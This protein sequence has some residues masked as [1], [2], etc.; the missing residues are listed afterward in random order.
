VEQV[1]EVVEADGQV[2]MILAEELP[3]EVDDLP[4]QLLGGLEVSGALQ[5]EGDIAQAV[6]D[7]WVFVA[8]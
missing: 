2:G 1:G 8:E 7:D 4:V 5:G 3:T 6:G